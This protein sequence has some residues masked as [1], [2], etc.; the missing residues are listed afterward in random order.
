MTKRT[1]LF[2]TALFFFSAVFIPAF[3]QAAEIGK[4]VKVT[5][6]GH[7]AFNLV[8][9]QGVNILIDPFLKNNPKTPAELKEVEKADFIL[10]THGHADHLGDTL[11][12]AQKTNATVV[13]MAEL[14]GYLTKKGVKNAV[15]MNKGGSYTAKGIRITMVNALHS[16]S[17]TEGDQVIYAGE[18][19]G[20][21]IRFENGF[22]VYHAGD[23]AVF[24]DMK[25]L[26]DLYK[27]NLALLPIGS[28][29][30]MDPNEAAYACKLLRPQYVVPMHY[31]TWP[32]LT[33]TAEEFAKLMK[34]QPE[35]KIL[36]M[37]PGQTIN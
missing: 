5:Y 11:A 3:S 6:L 21:I 13:A 27:P 26:S 36:I 28:H 4:G 35:V 30:T 24:Y 12:I 9:P 25:I 32:V 14:A 37:N 34:D 1:Y 23:T 15:R 7:A 2:F 18:P 8:S 29:F 33:G 19:V 22:T 17:V 16:S 10:V 31:G 20:F